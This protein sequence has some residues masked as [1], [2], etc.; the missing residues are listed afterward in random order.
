MVVLFGAPPAASAAPVPPTAMLNPTSPA[1]T[2][3]CVMESFLAP[4]LALPDP[5]AGAHRRQSLPGG[6]GRI[7]PRSSPVAK[8]GPGADGRTTPRRRAANSSQRLAPQA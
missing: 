5:H 1:M 8:P 3:R 4:A 6:A 7:A 2:L